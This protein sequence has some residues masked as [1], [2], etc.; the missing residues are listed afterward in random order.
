MSDDKVQSMV[1]D[2]LRFPMAIG[3]VFIHSRGLNLNVTNYNYGEVLLYDFIRNVFS[4]S[5]AEICVPTFF[6]FSGFLFFCKMKDWD[7]SF[8]INSI[9]KRIRTLIVPYILWNIIAI[10]GSLLFAFIYSIEKKDAVSIFVNELVSKGF[11]GVFWNWI[12]TPLHS[13]IMGWSTSLITPLDGP[14]W[15]MRD[16]IVVSLFSPIIYYV[17]KKTKYFGILLLSIAYLTQIWTFFPGFGI[18]SFFF[19]SSG[20][21]FSINGKNFVAE[22]YKARKICY[23]ISLVSFVLFLFWHSFLHIY[24]LRIFIFS[25]TISTINFISYL[26]K[27][28]KINVNLWLAKSSFFIFASHMILILPLASISYKYIFRPEKISS[29]LIQYFVVPVVTIGICLILYYLLQKFTP[30]FYGIITGNRK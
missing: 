27:Y 3:V 12:K 28:E 14:L 21:Y 20:A 18:S 6:F 15:F 22:F 23:I 17:I 5:I 13:N 9:Q 8:Y 26:V 7:L 30:R 1:I 29:L 11:Y 24:I 25:T 16:L 4:S 19:F 10:F 2:W